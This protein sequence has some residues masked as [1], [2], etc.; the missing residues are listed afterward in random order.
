MKKGEQSE[1]FP[2][3]PTG[4]NKNFWLYPKIMDDYW[5]ILTG[6]EQKVLTYILRRTWGFKKNTDEISLGQLETGIHRYDKGTGLSRPAAVMAIRKL[7]EKGF[8]KKSPGKKANC[9][10][11]VINL[12]YPDKKYLPVAGKENLHTINDVTIKDETIG[13]FS[14]QNKKISYENGIRWGEVPFFQGDKMVLTKEKI[15]KV[16]VKPE[17]GPD[18]KIFAGGEYWKEVEWRKK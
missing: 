2:G 17:E 7:I 12:S 1:K 4:P 13:N 8:I 9:Y 10:E 18:W 3:F 15:W 6:S 16:K 14:F 11:L 5:H